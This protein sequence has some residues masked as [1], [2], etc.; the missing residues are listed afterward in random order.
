VRSI[1]DGSKRTATRS[2]GFTV[3]C[4]AFRRR[5]K[6]N[7]ESDLRRIDNTADAFRRA[8]PCLRG[9]IDCP[10]GARRTGVDRYDINSLGTEFVSQV[11][12]ERG[13][14]RI[15]NRGDVIAGAPRRRRC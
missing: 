10:L 2:D 15:T 9:L 6:S 7:Q 4:D 11:L 13:N 1:V 3:D 5:Q 14:R 12:C 8:E